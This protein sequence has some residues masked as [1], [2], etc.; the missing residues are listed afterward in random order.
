MEAVRVQGFKMLPA[1][2]GDC[3][4]CNT[5][6][7]PHHAHDLSNIFYQTHFRLRHKRDPTWAD[8]CAHQTPLQCAAWRQGL[9]LAGHAWTEPDNDEPIAEPYAV[10]A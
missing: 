1:R 10:N 6:H 2:P 7:A 3:S 9:E 5:D 4:V 8:A